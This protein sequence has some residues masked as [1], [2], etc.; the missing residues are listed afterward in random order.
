MEMNSLGKPSVDLTIPARAEYVSIV[1]LTAS[2]VANRMGLDIEQIEDIKVA[3]SE[4][5]NRAVLMDSTGDG[6]C[7]L[8]FILAEDKLTI[9]FY[10]SKFNINDLFKEDEGLGLSLI[11]ALMDEVNVCSNGE[12][13]LEMIKII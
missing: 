6:T 11:N 12:K 2:G 3:I 5:C 1:R 10:S 13:T 9:L 4:V 8:R 7:S